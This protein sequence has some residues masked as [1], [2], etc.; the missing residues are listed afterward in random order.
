MHSSKS[1][2]DIIASTR[3]LSGGPS[4]VSSGIKVVRNN[5]QPCPLLLH[6]K[7]GGGVVAKVP[8]LRFRR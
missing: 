2:S 1:S 3:K 6:D 4:D 8:R 7:R 5:D